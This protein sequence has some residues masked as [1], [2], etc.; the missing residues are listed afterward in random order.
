MVIRSLKPFLL[1]LSNS[2]IDISWLTF[3]LVSFRFRCTTGYKLMSNLPVESK[4][5]Y[6]TFTT[7][8]SRAVGWCVLCPLELRR[9]ANVDLNELLNHKIVR[10]WHPEDGKLPNFERRFCLFRRNGAFSYYHH[11]TR[12]HGRFAAHFRCYGNVCFTITQK[13]KKRNTDNLQHNSNYNRQKK[14]IEA[15]REAQDALEKLETT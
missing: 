12:E 13:N 1:L 10:H 3:Y 9:F 15:N 14:T 4:C 8:F 7:T 11:K 2:V 6:S 5:Q